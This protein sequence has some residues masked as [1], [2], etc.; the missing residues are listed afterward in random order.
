M[1]LTSA[2]PLLLTAAFCCLPGCG[3]GE[4]A[5]EDTATY[6]VEGKVTFEDGQ[7]VQRARISFSSLE[8]EAQAEALTGDDGH[9]HIGGD[10]G[11][12]LPAGDYR[13]VVHPP[14]DEDGMPL[15]DSI[16]PKYAVKELSGLTATVRPTGNRYDVELERAE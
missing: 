7:P 11:E 10:H 5:D 15:N 12:G 9:Y 6:A 14:L 16:D 3:D 1:R 8:G 13:V 2:Y 4:T